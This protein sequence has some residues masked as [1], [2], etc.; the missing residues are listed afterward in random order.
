MLTELSVTMVKMLPPPFCCCVLLLWLQWMIRSCYFLVVASPC[1]S[2]ETTPRPR[3][4]YHGSLDASPTPGYQA[5]LATGPTARSFHGSRSLDTVTSKLQRQ[6]RVI[7]RGVL[8]R[9]SAVA[10]S[11]ELSITSVTLSNRTIVVNS[12]RSSTRSAVAEINSSNVRSDEDEKTPTTETAVTNGNQDVVTINTGVAEEGVT[13]SNQ[14]I[15]TH[16]E[17]N[18]VVTNS[19]QTLETTQEGSGACAEAI[20]TRDSCSAPYDS[21][22]DSQGKKVTRQQFFS[23]HWCVT[24]QCSAEEAES[25]AVCSICK[26]PFEQPSVVMH[27]TSCVFRL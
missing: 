16:E 12:N 22:S 24:Q 13:N 17:S 10:S 27:H 15:L 2:L 18:A 21:S 9:Q 25:R 19:N 23:P 14:Q 6:H 11:D 5:S 20:L 26:C 3:H 7:R 8:K 4:C 1:S